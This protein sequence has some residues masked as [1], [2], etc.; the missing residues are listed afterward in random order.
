MSPVLATTSRPSQIAVRVLRAFRNTHQDM[1]FL[2]ERSLTLPQAP[3]RASASTDHAH[4]P[5]T[6]QPTDH[7]HPPTTGQPHTW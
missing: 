5:A 2:W 1:A 7:A 4:P 3:P 6:G